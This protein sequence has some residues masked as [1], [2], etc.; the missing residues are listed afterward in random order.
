M[1]S[2]Q[3]D[4][5]AIDD[6]DCYG[7]TALVF[8]SFFEVNHIEIIVARFGAMSSCRLDFLIAIRISSLLRYEQSDN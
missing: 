6:S 3:L 4:S 1:I 7:L 5:V 8:A 2:P